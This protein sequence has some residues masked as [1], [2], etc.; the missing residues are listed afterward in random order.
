MRFIAVI[1]LMV[2]LFLPVNATAHQQ[3][4]NITVQNVKTL[5]QL[6]AQIES[7]SAY[8]FSYQGNLVENVTI[9]VT[10]LTRPVN[11]ILTEALRGTNLQFVIK[12]HDV[13]IT[14]KS[15]QP[16]K[17]TPNARKTI[18]GKVID[19]TTKDPIIGASIWLKDT[20]IG[21]NT[22]VNGNFKLSFTGNHSFISISSIGYTTQEA[23]IDNDNVMNIELQQGSAKI[24]EVVVVGYGTQ[25]KASVVGAISSV[26][27]ENMKVPVSKISS[28]LAGQLSGVITTQR[29]G[30]PGAGA[31]DFWIRGISTFGSNANPL[32]LV[33]GIERSMDLVDIE[34]IQ[35]YSIL[36]DASATAIYGVRGA[37]GVV[38]ITTRKGTE[39]LPKIS[40]KMENGILS[41]T[42]IPEMANSMQIAEMYNEAYGSAY[43]SEDVIQKYRDGSDPDLYPNVNWI[44][45]LYKKH[46][47]NQRINLN[48]SGGG[49]S[50][51]YYISAG[52]YNE[53]GLFRDDNMNAYN[54]SVFYRRFDFRS[55][56]DIKLHKNTTLNVNLA[57]TFERKNDPGTSAAS[58][59]SSAIICAANAFPMLYS[60]GSLPGPGANQGSNPYALLT[61]TGYNEKFYNTAQSL[62]GITQDLSDCV[63]KGLSANLKVSF[64]GVN[65]NAL[66]RTKVSA[67]YLAEGRDTNGNLILNN[68][69]VGDASLSYSQ[70]NSGYRT[71]YLEGTLNYTRSFKKHNVGGLF[72][73]Q[74]SQKNYIGTSA[75]E[76]E[77]ALPYRN[78][79]IAGR[80]TYDY[81]NRYFIE[82]NFGYNGSENFSPKHR[83]GFFPSVAAGWMISNED[84]FSNF[85][86]VIDMLKIRTSFGY[87]GNDKIGGNRRFIYNET[88][89]TGSSVY[90][91]QSIVNQSSVRLGDWANDQVG[92]EK[93]RKFNIGLDISLFN[94]LNIQADYF[95]EYRS[96]IFMSRASIPFFAGLTNQPW[97]NVGKMRNGGVDGSM[98]YHQKIGEVELSVRG[99]FTFARNHILDND[100]AAPAYPYL[101]E[102]GH[103]RW[104]NFGLVAVGLF[105]DQ[106]DIDSWPAQNYGDVKPG[107]VKYLDINGDRIVDSYDR[108]AIGYT[109]VPEIVYG[110][111]SSAKW[112]GFDF[113]VFFQ[114]VDH[115]NFFDNSNQTQAFVAKNMKEYS[116]FS[117]V[118]G[119]YWTT[120]NLDAKYPR[121]TI[122]TN[123]NNSQKSTFWMV[124]GR[125]IRLKNIELGYSL[126]RNVTSR[127]KIDGLRVYVSGVNL[128]TFSDFKLWDPD[129]QSTGPGGY[130]NNKVVNVGASLTF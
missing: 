7:T 11:E 52:Y 56:V 117:D 118:Y 107:D 13:I 97:V 53:N 57:N 9:N 93:S 23:E 73:F 78:M 119:N 83:F 49:S 29:S 42:K 50:V 76:S 100:Q 96:G 45:S 65:N 123:S 8:R 116:I 130:P 37:N 47:D 121:L 27:I 70:S 124:N 33:D 129:L 30:E 51:K 108:K 106:A 35:E 55:N 21:A 3:E 32:V 48:V 24:D 46:S 105:K 31:T 89:E 86:N 101:D 114:G 85:T 2:C 90:L 25:K 91:G 12:D 110:F 81:D 40:L 128:L 98:D 67:Q 126:P 62:F 14:K 74:Q 41:P 102:T 4:R 109:D 26:K 103:P 18:S 63:T 61:R 34:D 5:R 1:G 19:E 6:I 75:G 68:T 77:D 99:S 120:D 38:L 28:C 66:S 111:G 60:D 39:G 20:P 79:G 72:L 88:V 71:F 84:F 115:V 87:A 127:L 94:K 92:W 58:I 112:K 82:G 122:G 59:W 95:N 80:A 69:N 125:Y 15:N 44:E 64:D 104:Q 22:D 36:K 43:Y 54:T 17:T 10:N 16:A 113:S